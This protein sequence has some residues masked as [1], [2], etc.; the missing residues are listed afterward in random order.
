MVNNDSTTAVFMID[1]DFYHQHR[2]GYE[3]M[4]FRDEEWLYIWG[5]DK[6]QDAELI[7]RHCNDSHY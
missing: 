6:Q 7:I 4:D 1:T 5:D 2:W 3:H